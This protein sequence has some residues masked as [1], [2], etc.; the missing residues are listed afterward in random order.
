MRMVSFAWSLP[1]L[2]LGACADGGQY[3]SLAKRP[4][5]A[6]AKDLTTQPVPQP[7]V[8]A[9]SDRQVAGRI[10]A[11]LGRA[12]ASQAGFEKA[13]AEAR[14]IVARGATSARESEPWIAAQLA[15]SALDKAREP[16]KS[17]LSDLD[18]EW[19]QLLAAP[20]SEDR[21]ALRS[22]LAR[23]E[24]I[25]RAQDAGYRTLLDAIGR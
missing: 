6:Q 13:L 7:A 19:R 24:A 10:A 9:P 21:A 23:I 1:L 3:P 16:V 8:I 11:A 2:A 18:N 5:E 14:P 25:D 20:P 17:A 12:E 15:V 22:A 4:V